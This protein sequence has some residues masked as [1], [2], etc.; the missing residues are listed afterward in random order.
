MPVGAKMVV[1]FKACVEHRLSLAFGHAFEFV[2]VVV[3]QTDVFHWF[4]FVSCDSLFLM[5]QSR[6][7]SFCYQIVVREAENRQLLIFLACIRGTFSARRSACFGS[8]NLSFPWSGSFLFSTGGSKLGIPKPIS[9]SS[10]RPLA[11]SASSSFLSRSF[12]SQ[13]LASRCPC[14]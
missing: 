2:F 14:F 9:V 12:Y 5:T 1:V 6:S 13:Y 3:S 8:T 10:P 4:L 7:V 11:S